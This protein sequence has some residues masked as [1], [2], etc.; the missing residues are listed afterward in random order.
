MAARPTRLGSG[1]SCGP[2][3]APTAEAHVIE[4]YTRKMKA[5]TMG[6]RFIAQGDPETLNLASHL[7]DL[8]GI[9]ESICDLNDLKELDLSNNQIHSLHGGLLLFLLM[10]FAA[11]ESTEERDLRRRNLA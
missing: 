5:A 9:S 11:I 7:S 1:L 2:R 6:F 4:V 10:E 8:K 3:S